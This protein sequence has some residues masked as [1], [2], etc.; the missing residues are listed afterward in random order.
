[1]TETS[2]VEKLYE[3]RTEALGVV[4]LE[5]WPEGLVL[6]VG[7]TILWKSWGTAHE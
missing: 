1:M 2:G 7:S 3:E 5:R 4:R 6:W